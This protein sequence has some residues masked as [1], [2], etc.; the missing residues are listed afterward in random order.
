VDILTIRFAWGTFVCWLI[1][2]FLLISFAGGIR[3]GRIH[4]ADPSS[5]YS[6][7]REPVKF[8]A[9][10]LLYLFFAVLSFIVWKKMVI[11]GF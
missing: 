1:I 5:V 7:K 3:S 10:V 8:W 11:G 4:C 9:I 6:R 2:S